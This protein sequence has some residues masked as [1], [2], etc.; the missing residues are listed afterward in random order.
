MKFWEA[1][2]AAIED[3]AWITVNRGAGGFI[4]GL[5]DRGG[6]D[7][8]THYQIG[9]FGPA[10][11]EPVVNLPGGGQVVGAPFKRIM[12]ADYGAFTMLQGIGRCSGEQQNDVSSPQSAEPAQGVPSEDGG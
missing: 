3:G 1:L 12:E 4:V 10:A 9:Y 2:R 7:M 11:G 6:G 5:G 8:S